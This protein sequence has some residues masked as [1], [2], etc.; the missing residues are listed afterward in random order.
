VTEAVLLKH[1]LSVSDCKDEVSSRIRNLQERKTGHQQQQGNQPLLLL[2]VAMT[3]LVACRYE[4]VAQANQ[5]TSW[6]AA[7]PLAQCRGCTCVRRCCRAESHCH[8][9]SE[10]EEQP[11]RS[12]S[13]P[14]LRPST[15]QPTKARQH[16]SF[17]AR[18]GVV[19]FSISQHHHPV[20]PASHLAI[21]ICKIETMSTRQQTA[22]LAEVTLT[23][24]S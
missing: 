7:F 24:S 20:L 1:V 11:R 21:I 10:E 6:C 23:N 14:P 2:T 4:A 9:C 16:S 18:F 8:L 17:V 15:Q 5:A 12:H 3:L 22:G 13:Q 19:L